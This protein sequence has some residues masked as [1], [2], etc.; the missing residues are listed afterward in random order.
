M[1]KRIHHIIGMT[2]I[3][4]MLS[5]ALSIFIIGTLSSVYIITQKNYQYQAAFTSILENGRTA[6]AILQYHVGYAGFTGCAVLPEQALKG[7]DHTIR[8]LHGDPVNN[9]LMQDMQYTDHLFISPKP[10]YKKNDWMMISDCHDTA[11]FQIDH[12]SQYQGIQRL[13]LLNALKK[14]FLKPAE[15]SRYRVNTF[16]TGKTGRKTRFGG[17]VSAMYVENIRHRTTELVEGI[18]ALD[19][20]YDAEE[21]GIIVTRSAN[22]IRNWSKVKGVT[23]RLTLSSTEGLPMQ[24]VMYGYISLREVL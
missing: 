11:F 21:D 1:S 20:S 22:Q 2:L 16:Y 12:I 8:V 13:Q 4:L 9:A 10:L 15:V 18:D 6:I 3:E 14:R 5:M 7:T 17:E 24:K 19:F 23:V